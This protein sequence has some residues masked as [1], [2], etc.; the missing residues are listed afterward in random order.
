MGTSFLFIFL[1]I[2]LPRK[3]QLSSHAPSG[4]LCGPDFC[5]S[6]PAGQ[7]EIQGAESHLPEVR[8]WVIKLG[9]EPSYFPALGYVTTAC[10]EPN[11]PSSKNFFF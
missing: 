1:V 8:V 4:S 9:L 5:P 10:S 11:V 7:T 2:Y 3:V 6:V